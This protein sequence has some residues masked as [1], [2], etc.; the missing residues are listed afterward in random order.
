MIIKNGNVLN[1][2]FEFMKSDVSVNGSKIDKIGESIDGDNVLDATNCYVVPGFVDTHMHGALANTF[3]D[4]TDDTAKIISEY[5][6]KNGTTSLVPAISAAKRE[7]LE[8]VCAHMNKCVGFSNENAAEIHGFH[9]E[10]P[11]FS[12][13]YKGAHLPENIRIPSVEELSAYVGISGK[14]IKILT[15]A[16]ELDN[17]EETIKYAVSKGICVSVGHTDATYED[18]VN[19]EKW[20]ATQATHLF[21]A[22]SALNHRQPG[23]VGGALGSDGIKCEIIC[24][25]FHVHPTV[26]KMAY[27]IKGRDKINMITDSEVGTGLAD[28]EYDVNGRKIIVKNNQTRCEDGTIAGGTT[29]LIDGV[30]N[31]ASIGIPLEDACMM[32]SKNPALAAKIYDKTGSITVGKNADILI[33]DKEL[34]LKKVILRGNPL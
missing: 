26:V 33:L 11:F 12:V 14:N 13:K 19:A 4:Y 29:C 23:T 18:V 10:G 24:D 34:N 17:A 27:K 3:I 6:A 28:G 5:E 21:N 2:N 31:L 7:K 30:R 32:A 20:G 1:D 22:M 9:L 16:P 15:I 8:K 25:F